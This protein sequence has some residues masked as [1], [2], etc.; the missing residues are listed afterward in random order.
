MVLFPLDDREDELEGS[1]SVRGSDHL[2]YIRYPRVR[3]GDAEDG[4]GGSDVSRRLRCDA[5]LH[6]LLAP[7]EALLQQRLDQS[8][9]LQHFL[10]ELRDI[11]D[12]ASDA[13]DAAARV[14]RT[15]TLGGEGTRV[16][17][18]AGRPLLSAGFYRA[19]VRDL[20]AVGW[21]RVQFGGGEGGSA[22]G[23][24][25]TQFDIT[26]QCVLGGG[27]CFVSRICLCRQWALLS[28]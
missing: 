20:D 2:V 8:A 27:V 10:A 4:C 25:V 11:A 3:R 28:P 21:D 18:T 5:T 14:V 19:L 16:P 22:D 13:R 6:T 23:T 26:F 1:L 24:D 17:G 9:S 7:H 12:R 15:V